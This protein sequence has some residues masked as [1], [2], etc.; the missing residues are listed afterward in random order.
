M[1]RCVPIPRL[2]RRDQR[3]PHR[4]AHRPAGRGTRRAHRRRGG[5]TR[6]V[7]RRGCNRYAADGSLLATVQ[8]PVERP[9][10]CAFGGPGRDTLFVTSARTDLDDDELGRQPLAAG[11]SRSTDWVSVACPA[12][13]IAAGHRSHLAGSAIPETV[14]L[15]LSCQVRPSGKVVVDLSQRPE[16]DPPGTTRPGVTTPRDRPARIGAR[17]SSCRAR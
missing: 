7:E 17:R 8:L 4:R 15:E 3:P 9:T 6:S 11:C 5:W 10:S 12:C 14:P 16:R 2:H 1:R 13:H